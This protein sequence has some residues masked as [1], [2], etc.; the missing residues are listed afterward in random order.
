MIPRDI[1]FNFKNKMIIEQVIINTEKS[2]KEFLQEIGFELGDSVL[3]TS[4]ITELSNQEIRS[5]KK[6]SQ[7]KVLRERDKKSIIFKERL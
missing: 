5:F 7:L 4:W 3:L 1:L 2:R 6:K